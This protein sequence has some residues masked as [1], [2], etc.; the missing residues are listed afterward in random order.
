MN[1]KI[2]ENVSFF[3][4]FSILLLYFLLQI[5]LNFAKQQNKDVSFGNVIWKKPTGGIGEAM[6]HT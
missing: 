6:G 3:F 1:F 4:F 5:H 2:I